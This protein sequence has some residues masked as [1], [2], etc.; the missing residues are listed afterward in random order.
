M[1]KTLLLVVLSVMVF[2]GCGSQKRIVVNQKTYPS[3]YENPPRSSGDVMYEVGEGSTKQDAINNALSM[4]VATLSVSIESKYRSKTVENQGVVENFQKTVSNEITSDVKKIRISHY[5][6]INSEAFGF[7]KYLVLIRSDKKRLFE[8]L[9]HELDQRF[10]M[11]DKQRTNVASENTLKQVAFYQQTL[12]HL[13]DVPDTLT[14]MHVLNASFEGNRYLDKIASIKAETSKLLYAL[15][16]SIKT[17]VQA[18]NLAAPIRNGLSIKQYQIND[19]LDKN[20]FIIVVNSSVEKAQAYGFTLA[21]T[22]IAI[23]VK[24]HKGTIIGSNKLNIIGQSTQG[25]GIAQENVA[26]KFN[27]MIEDEGIEKVLGLGL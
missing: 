16:F 1:K 22:A 24:D 2:F 9:E 18:K 27:T 8:S 14:V 26:I 19:T 13:E 3:W 20:H 5:E 17:N 15:S 23:N 12:S 4:M 10:S 11:I 25:Y 7:K 6:L 21:R